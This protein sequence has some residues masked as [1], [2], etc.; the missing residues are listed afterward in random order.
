MDDTHLMMRCDSGGYLNV[1]KSTW[2]GINNNENDKIKS[3]DR[4]Q[5]G[6]SCE[7]GGG[8]GLYGGGGGGDGG[9][10][11][12]CGVMGTEVTRWYGGGIG[13]HV[14]LMDNIMSES[15]NRASG[16]EGTVFFRQPTD[17]QQS[18]VR[19]FVIVLYAPLLS[20]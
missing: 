16:P 7:G 20:L 15:L 14:G 2:W 12:E 9:G 18:L 3:E 19:F 1:R 6:G 13:G 8:G 10:G 17:Q 4:Q 5:C 11:Q